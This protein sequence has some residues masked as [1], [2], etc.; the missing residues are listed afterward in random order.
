MRILTCG[1]DALLIEVADLTEAGEVY[2]RLRRDLPRG[3]VELVPAARTVLV[4][5]DRTATDAARLREHLRAGAVR[6]G[7]ADP[8]G[9]RATPGST[10]PVTVTVRYDGPDLADVAGLTGLTPR[11]VVERHTG[12]SHRVAFCGFA[13]GFAYIAGLDP[14]LRVPRRATPRTRV[15]PGAVAIADLFTGVYPRASPGGWHLIGHTDLVTFDLDR[16]PPAL[17]AP[18]TPVRFVDVGN[19]AAETTRGPA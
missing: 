4:Q 1:A 9:G 19:S 3:V 10:P 13:P 15:P 16:D 17:L 2:D 5:F 18:G 14:G 12:G 8:V 7:D 11:Q 6:A